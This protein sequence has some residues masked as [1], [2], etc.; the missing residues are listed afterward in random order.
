MSCNLNGE[1]MLHFVRL[2]LEIVQ[3]LLVL[4]GGALARTQDIWL[5][6]AFHRFC[7]DINWNMLLNSS[8]APWHTCFPG[9]CLPR[10][11]LLHLCNGGR[12]TL[13]TPAPNLAKMRLVLEQ[14]LPAATTHTTHGFTPLDL[15]LTACLSQI[16]L[17]A[18]P[19]V[20]QGN[21][22][23]SARDLQRGANIQFQS[24]LHL[25]VV[26]A[27]ASLF[28]LPALADVCDNL[29]LLITLPGASAC[30]QRVEWVLQ[31]PPRAQA[32]RRQ[33]AHAAAQQHQLQRTAQ[34]RAPAARAAPQRD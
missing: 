6:F 28:K 20:M 3:M 33:P 30:L 9:L 34:R 22:P 32:P 24:P 8:V 14:Y 13:V 25:T 18:H 26:C 16:L 19:P 12:N 5:G 23:P 7:T 17:Q 15:S 2:N 27:H 4:E 10:A 21:H 31:G 1:N 29:A 11:H